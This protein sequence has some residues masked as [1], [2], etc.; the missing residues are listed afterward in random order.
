MRHKFSAS[1]LPL[2]ACLL[3]AFAPVALRG[4]TP[5]EVAIPSGS[6]TVH[7]LLYLPAASGHHP[8]LVVIHEWWGLNDWI[9]QQAQQFAA[10]GYVTLAVDLYRGKVAND[11]ETAHELMRGLPQD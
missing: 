8:A 2:L 5:Q 11:P 4:Q 9:K 3:L 6:E 1:L 10:Q 7:G